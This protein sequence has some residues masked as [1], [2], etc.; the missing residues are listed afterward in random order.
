MLFL[1]ISPESKYDVPMECEKFFHPATLFAN[2][3]YLVN[4]IQNIVALNYQI[5]IEFYQVPS[6][7]QLLICRLGGQMLQTFFEVPLAGEISVF[8]LFLLSAN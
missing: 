7:L 4:P 8:S 1:Y 6:A 3:S 2:H 5:I